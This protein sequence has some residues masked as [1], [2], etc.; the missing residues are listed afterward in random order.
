[1][2]NFNFFILPVIYS[3]K[4]LFRKNFTP[5]CYQFFSKQSL[6]NKGWVFLSNSH[7]TVEE[8]LHTKYQFS[9]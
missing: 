3:S 5:E 9:T 2:Y 1:M 6:L 7:L 8:I 4:D